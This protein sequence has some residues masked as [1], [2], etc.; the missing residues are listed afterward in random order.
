[1]AGHLAS[2]LPSGR[3][4][5]DQRVARSLPTAVSRSSERPR[6][7]LG[8]PLDQG[9]PRAFPTVPERN[10]IDGPDAWR[11]GLAF[12][13]DGLPFHAHEVFEQRWK[14]APASERDCWQ[15]LAQWGAALTQAARGNDIGK[16]RIAVRAKER[17]D[18]AC[19]ASGVPQYVDVKSVVDSLAQLA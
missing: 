8:R 6:D 14:C 11:E 3:A 7:S 10:F 17:L 4:P 2:H 16:Q 5:T 18:Q 15:A 13:S 1:M 9:D 12:L 19:R